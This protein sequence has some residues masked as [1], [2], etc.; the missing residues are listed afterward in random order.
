MIAFLFYK[1]F[2]K[3]YKINFLYKNS[4]YINTNTLWLKVIYIKTKDVIIFLLLFFVAFNVSSAYVIKNLNIDCIVTP[5]DTINETISFVIYN[6][7]DKNLSHISYTIPQTIRNFTINASAGVKGYSALYNEGVTEIAIEFEKPI[8]KGGYTNITINCFVNDAIWTKNGIKQLILSFPITSK[9]ATIKIV[10]PPGAV[11]LSPQGTLL[12]TPS[13][14]KITT[15]G[16]HQIIVWDLSLNKEITFTI[17][18]KYTFISYPGQNIIEQPAINNN[19]KYLLIIAIFGTAIFGGLF[20]KEKIS[21]RKIIERTKNIKNELTSLKNKLK[22]KEEEIKNLAI[23][24][25]DLEDKLSKANKNLLNKDEIISVLNER[26]SE[27]ESQIQKLLDENII[28]KEKIESLNKY[29]ETLKKENDKLKDKVRELSD[30]AKKY[31]EEKRGVLWSF[32]TEDEKII[33]DLI[34]KHGHITQKEIVEITGMS[35]PKVSRI[36]SELEDRKIIRKEKIG[37]I[38]KLTLTEESKKLL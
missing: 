14:Y 35:K 10:L 6:N 36:I 9:N 11:I 28:Y 38:N 37:R 12:V 5:D 16:K 22:E 30:I 23:K 34:K 7:E 21:K 17:T 18:V 8:P 15:D 29:I 32:L 2:A 24:I 1:C 19:L 3:N 20:V 31:M 26:I 13:G 27:Y 33:I 4:S 25:K